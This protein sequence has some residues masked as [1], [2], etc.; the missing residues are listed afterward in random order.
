[1]EETE[2]IV[3]I[4]GVE[5]RRTCFA[6]PEQYNA[7]VDGVQVGYLRL[8]HGYFTV[9]VPDCG[10]KTVYEAEPDGDGVFDF[11]ERDLYLKEAVAAIR[12]TLSA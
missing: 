7:Y 2:G 10:G 12:L 1:M 4:S 3:E 8:R 5:L 11:E 9:E 6:C